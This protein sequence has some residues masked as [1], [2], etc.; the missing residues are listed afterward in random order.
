LFCLPELT[1]KF[2][3][4]APTLEGQYILKNLIFVAAGWTVLF[5]YVM[6]GGGRRSDQALAQGRLEN[7]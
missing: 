2:L 7:P 6:S 5:P 3:P 1:F 4:F